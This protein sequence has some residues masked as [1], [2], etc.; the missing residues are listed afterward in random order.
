MKSLN[1]KFAATA[2]T[3]L[4]SI[5]CNAQTEVFK[6]NGELT[7]AISK[8]SR[9]TNNLTVA[10]YPVPISG[11]DWVFTN[12]SSSYTTGGSS[13]LV[14]VRAAFVRRENAKLAEGFSV[15]ATT[16]QSGAPG[17]EGDPCGAPHIERINVVRGRLDRCAVAAIKTVPVSGIPTKSLAVFF[18]ET[19]QDGRYLRYENVLFYEN[20][21][22]PESRLQEAEFRSNLKDWM[23]KMLQATIKASDY[24]K[25]SNAFDGL[26]SLLEVAVKNSLNYSRTPSNTNTITPEAPKPQTTLASPST[27]TA[28]GNSPAVRLQ[29]LEDLYKKG[30]VSEQE[31]K[32][33]REE[34]LREI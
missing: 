3:L 9:V 13:P 21:G 4:F 20:M 7:G 27:P 25:P 28:I 23:S 19:N 32:Q 15:V 26:P 8:N 30:L 10:G 34:I 6:T 14:M 16:G 22:I 31:Y 33:K 11:S 12:S 1:V 5:I 17:W 29:T 18:L 2:L 24:S